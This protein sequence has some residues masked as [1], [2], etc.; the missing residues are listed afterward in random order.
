VCVVLEHTDT[1]ESFDLGCYDS[2]KFSCGACT[3]AAV[4]S[5]FTSAV[6]LSESN[7]SPFPSFATDFVAN[8][9][10]ETLKPFIS[11]W[12]LVL[13][14]GSSDP[15]PTKIT[16][17]LAFTPAKTSR[18]L[19]TASV[20]FEVVPTSTSIISAPIISQPQHHYVD[21]IESAFDSVST[22]SLSPSVGSL[23]G[24]SGKSFRLFM[25][26]LSSL[27]PPSSHYLEVGVF[28]GATFLATCSANPSIRCTAIDN[29]SSFTNWSP[30]ENLL[31]SMKEVIDDLGRVEVHDRD[32][33]NPPPLAPFT[34]YFYDGPH[35]LSA[36]YLSILLYHQSAA[37]EFVFV[38]DDWNFPSVRD[39]TYKGIEDSGSRILYKREVVTT[40][41]EL[42]EEE[43]E[44]EGW[45]NGMAVFVIAK[46]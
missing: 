25:S 18:I 8:P 26:T 14:F 34:L 44:E 42:V 10:A 31:E 27:L 40:K 3:T 21:L 28:K 30:K 17:S 23:H 12:E 38:V 2:S 39:G 45:H 5:F 24:M 7:I 9:N 19:S 35:T 20:E 37:D 33:N 41:N 1:E 32:F 46:E 43:G 15:A 4:S 29:F 22:T 16:A 6:R 11:E 36:H 13:N